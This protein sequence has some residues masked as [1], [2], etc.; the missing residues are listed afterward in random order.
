MNT[1]LLRKA[2]IIS[3]SIVI[4][5][6]GIAQN[7]HEVSFFGGGGLSTLSYSPKEGKQK[8]NFGYSV[9]VDYNFYFSSNFSI[10]SGLSLSDY[11][12]KLEMNSLSDKYLTQD[13]GGEPFELQYQ[14]D[15]YEEKQNMMSLNIPIMLQYEQGSKTKFYVA[16]GVKIGIPVKSESE[17]SSAKIKA[18]GYFPQW[19][20]TPIDEPEFMGFG[21]FNSLKSTYDLD[22]SLAV[23]LSLEAGVKWQLSDKLSLYTGVYCDFGVNDINKENNKNWLIYNKDYPTNYVFN[24]A[25]ASSINKNGEQKDVV[26]K[27]TP[28]AIGAKISLA[29][30]L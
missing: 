1:Q 20:E 15:N 22:F 10:K 19:S 25:L 26:K 4:S 2:I 28:M 8:D 12:S 21:N 27:V 3:I 16:G 17:I 11:N 23:M 30:E 13:I 9:G 24:S 18:L 29:V 5:V 6:A 7:R 14:V